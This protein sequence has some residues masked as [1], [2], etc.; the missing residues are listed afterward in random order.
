MSIEMKPQKK[1]NNAFIRRMVLLG[2]VGLVLFFI[3]CVPGVPIAVNGITPNMLVALT[4]AVAFFFGE[5]A[6][7]FYGLFAGI[8]LDMY[9]VSGLPVNAML[10]LVLGCVCGL[11]ARLFFSRNFPAALLCCLA[12]LFVYYGV[13]LLAFKGGLSDYGRAYFLSQSIPGIF[14]SLA[15]FVPWYFLCK[16]LSKG[17]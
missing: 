9:S 17:I 1:R 5:K 10:L 2:A 13:C 12:Y 6:G 8:L 7:G 16:K 4:T 3:Q 11:L 15:F 14:Y